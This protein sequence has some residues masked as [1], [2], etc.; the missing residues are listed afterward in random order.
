VRELG[1]LS[2]RWEPALWVETA[3][4]PARAA[5]SRS[6]AA[7]WMD[8]LGRRHKIVLVGRQQPPCLPS[9]STVTTSSSMAANSRLSSAGSRATSPEL[10]RRRR[11]VRVK[12]APD[13]THSGFER[14]LLTPPAP[15]GEPTEGGSAALPGPE[16]LPSAAA[17]PTAI[18]ELALLPT[19]P[20]FSATV[21][22]RPAA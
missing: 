13:H 12:E 8:G 21:G 1:A 18:G 3:R 2:E 6:S 15:V 7:R 4:V 16:H 10:G 20:P 19:H 22:R 17:H 9:T 14:I 5:G 11:P